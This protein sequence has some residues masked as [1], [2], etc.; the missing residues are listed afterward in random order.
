MKMSKILIN[1]NNLSEIDEYKKIGITNFLFAVDEFSIGY[2]TFDIKDI[3]DDAYIL[4]NRVFDCDTVDDLVRCQEEFKRFK[5]IIYEDI[6]VF[7]TFRHSNLELIWFQNHFQTNQESIEFWLKNGCS[8][9][10]ISNEIT[11][12]EIID[13]INNSSKPLV[14][15][16]FA[17]N[18]IMYSRRTLLTNFNK[19]NNLDD[20]NDM[21]LYEPH[22]NNEFLARENSYGTI[23]YNNTYFNY[24]PLMSKVD[25]AK[26]KFYLVMNLDL[27]P[28]DIEKI[29]KGESCGDS[30]FLDKKT[31][32]RMSEYNDR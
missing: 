4:M 21:T 20:Y 26:I 6:A 2:N 11:E 3:P 16:I 1:I 10:V 27:K 15:N 24:V 17:K 25:D 29:L 7:N 30:G 14:L 12:N 18:Q 8:S 5:G 32:Y 22:T 13:I 31:V 19:Y 28:R 9:S 23:I